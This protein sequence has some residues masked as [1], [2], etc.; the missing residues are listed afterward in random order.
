MLQKADGQQWAREQWWSTW[1]DG[2]DDGIYDLD[3]QQ[4]L[5]GR[6]FLQKAHV[7]DCLCTTLPTAVRADSAEPVAIPL[8]LMW[9]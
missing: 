9:L 8:C 2:D 3:V 1:E 7:H 4:L 6:V 5:E